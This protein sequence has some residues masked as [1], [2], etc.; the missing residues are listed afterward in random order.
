LL[1]FIHWNYST[2]FVHCGEDINMGC[3]THI[4]ISQ[5]WSDFE[6][7]HAAQGQS[8]HKEFYNYLL[9]DSN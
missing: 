6:H 3:F 1:I 2:G 9:A 7:W 4:W 5:I 8:A